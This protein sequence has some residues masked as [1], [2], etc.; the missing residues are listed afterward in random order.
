MEM[1]DLKSILKAWGHA[2][3]NRYAFTRAERQVHM[4]GKARD[5]AP[6]KHAERELVGRSGV[7]RRLYMARAI[8]DCG[9][10]IVPLWACDPVPARNDASR[11]HDNP[12]IAVDQGVPD[13]LRWVDSALSRMTRQFPMRA[14]VLWTEYTVSAS[15]AI[16]SRMVSET[17]EGAF[18]Y[19]MYRRELEKAHELLL[20]ERANVAA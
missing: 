9:K 5:M 3:V 18:T 14:R 1:D 8:S 11:P 10:R 19:S 4:L 16:K 6:G 13:D 20:W 2:H 17:Y 12:E 15:Q 7:S